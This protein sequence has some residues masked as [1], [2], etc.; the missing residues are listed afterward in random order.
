MLLKHVKYYHTACTN[1]V[2]SLKSW[3]VLCLFSI[4]TLS[5]QAQKSVHQEY[6]VKK[7]GLQHLL[8]LSTLGDPQKTLERIA[9]LKDSLELSPKDYKWHCLEWFKR[10]NETW[11]S[12]NE[13]SLNDWKS[14]IDRSK[15]FKNSYIHRLFRYSYNEHRIFDNARSGTKVDL[16][17]LLE[18][19][20]VANK[21]SD[22]QMVFDGYILIADVHIDLNNRKNALKWLDRA[23]KALSYIDDDANKSLF[24]TFSA[25]AQN[26]EKHDSLGSL[27]WKSEKHKKKAVDDAKKGIYFG[28]LATKKGQGK[29][30]QLHLSYCILSDFTVD[31]RECLK[32]EKRALVSGYILKNLLV[33][34]QYQS[35]IGSVY[36]SLNS[37][38]SAKMYFDSSA[39]IMN[40]SGVHFN[41][42]TNLRY[43]EYY[44]ALGNN[45]SLVKYLRLYHSSSMKLNVE[46]AAVNLSLSESTF[47]DEKQKSTIR[48]QQLILTQEK[49]RSRWYTGSFIISLLFV[50]MMLFILFH[51]RKRKREVEAQKAEVDIVNHRLE[52]LL[53]ENK[54]L[55]NETHHRVKNNLQVISSLLESQAEVAG[56]KVAKDAIISAQSR[57]GTMAY[58]HDLLYKQDDHSNLEIGPYLASLATQVARFHRDEDNLH[59]TVNCDNIQYPLHRAIHTGIFVNELLTNSHKHARVQD[60]QLKIEIDLIE[61]TDN[62]VLRFKDNGPGLIKGLETERKGS[63]GLYL[64]KSMAR[65]LRGKLTYENNEGSIFTLNCKK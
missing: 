32:Y 24:Y 57:I 37:L 50:L 54:V 20:E 52:T 19:I 27:D 28:E 59:V 36:L 3:F 49:S 11:N 47:E 60:K 6:V 55:M 31:N 23:K 16:T 5:S 26:P 1:I 8:P 40:S 39:M 21:K 4:I 45:D 33:N 9:F 48:E 42:R 13:K 44:S 64:L 51:L 35:R 65:Q 46:Q 29:F 22:Y 17:N 7:L 62:Y 58:V 14:G 56:N 38:D 10:K 41:N 25:D 15:A 2:C 61:N 30:I 53:E 12:E 43:V 34:A 63:I 18:A